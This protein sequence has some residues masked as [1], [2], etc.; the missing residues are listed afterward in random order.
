MLKSP[1][2]MLTDAPRTQFCQGRHV[3]PFSFSVDVSWSELDGDVYSDLEKDMIQST[4]EPTPT[5]SQW[6]LPTTAWK[7]AE[8]VAVYTGTARSASVTVTYLLECSSL[9]AV[10]G[11]VNHVVAVKEVEILGAVDPWSIH[12]PSLV[13]TYIPVQSDPEASIVV[14]AKLNRRTYHHGDTI[15]VRYRISN[16]FSAPIKEI[17]FSLLNSAMM[18]D[19]LLDTVLPTLHTTSI[20]SVVDQTLIQ[21]NTDVD[22]LIT[23]AVPSKALPR[24]S[25]TLHGKEGSVGDAAA[26][27]HDISKKSQTKIRFESILRIALIL[28]NFQ[29]HIFQTT[30]SISPSPRPLNID[31]TTNEKLTPEQMQSARQIIWVNDR[32]AARCAHCTGVFSFLHRKHH[33]RGCGLIVCS[34]HS[35][36]MPAPKLFGLKPRRV[37]KACEALINSGQLTGNVRSDHQLSGEP[38]TDD[39]LPIVRVHHE[40]YALQMASLQLELGS[41]QKID[42]LP[43]WEQTTTANPNSQEQTGT[44][45]N[46]ASDAQTSNSDDVE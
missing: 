46:S 32:E 2:S 21:P 19:N 10:R 16:R 40:A 42:V 22:K 13:G 5:S 39:D 14:R 8:D 24:W 45:T 31:N 25:T 26:A 43:N 11:S 29:D 6:M 18:R 4:L 17:Q 35:K 23:L 3:L 7:H 34:D 1:I 9:C 36:S 30:L 12:S 38:K 41:N 33:C 28:D 44:G 37:C 15:S 20:S 27:G